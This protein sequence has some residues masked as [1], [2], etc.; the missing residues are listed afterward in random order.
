MRLVRCLDCGHV[1]HPGFDARQA[2]GCGLAGREECDTRVRDL[3]LAR[4]PARPAVIEIGHGRGA[5]LEALATA[6][7]GRYTGFDAGGAG[8]SGVAGVELRQTAF[9][10]LTDVAALKPDLVIARRL[11]ACGA[12]PLG[13]IETVAFAAAA[14]GLSPAL[15]LEVPCADRAIESGRAEDFY[16]EQ[17]SNFTTASFSRMLARVSGSIEAL[18]H[19][20]GGERL[21]AVVR[22]EGRAEHRERARRAKA[23]A[24]MT[25]AWRHV[26][27]LELANLYLAGKRVAVWGGSGASAAFLNTHH[28][29]AQRFPLVVDSDALQVGRY[30]PGTGQRIQA[31]EVLKEKPADVVLVA[32]PWR[33]GE[34]ATEMA[35]ASLA[36]ARILIPHEGRLV[37]YRP[38]ESGADLDRTVEL[39]LAAG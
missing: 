36:A 11:E 9:A 27:M 13:W 20:G 22:L 7:P 21:C 39:L 5:L 28:M 19:L 29:D 38:A 4:L 8:Q 32:S 6:R 37:E 24:E 10:P 33:A 15:Y 23:F 17:H 3:L 35:R 14:H 25:V 31:V 16:Y 1:F 18:D 12:D 34:A 26:L 2:A 30:V